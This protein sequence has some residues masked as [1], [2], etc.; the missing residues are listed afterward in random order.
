MSDDGETAVPLRSA[1]AAPTIRRT[2][3]T[4][5]DA[6][7]RC[8]QECLSG[9]SDAFA[10]IVARYQKPLFN[11]IYQMVHDYEDAREIAQTAFLKAFSN[12]HGFDQS[13]RFFSW[14]CRIAMNESINVATSRK[15]SEP[16]V[17]DFAST[18]A[19]PEDRAEASEIRAVLRRA[20]QALTADYRAVITLRHIA[21]CSYRETAEILGIPEKTVKS[22]LFSARQI[23][24]EQLKERG[25]GE[26]L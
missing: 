21:G 11:V 1:E 12:L 6:D 22:R 25:Y 8:V 20:L 2:S 7:V 19:S 9:R 26:R 10:E 14:L 16:I 24:R 13:R 18:A 15:Q 4:Y 5:D 23:L 17:S 3:G